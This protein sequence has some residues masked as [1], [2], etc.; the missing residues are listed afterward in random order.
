MGENQLTDKDIAEAFRMLLEDEDD[1]EV[2]QECR[3]FIGTEQKTPPLVG[4][5][6]CDL[7]KIFQ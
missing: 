4:G 5:D 6:E 3:A 1:P 2:A 7:G